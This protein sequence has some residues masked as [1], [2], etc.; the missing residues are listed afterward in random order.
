MTIDLRMRFG[1]H[2]GEKDYNRAIADLIRAERHD[3]A[4]ERLTADLASLN[5]N[6]KGSR[7]YRPQSMYSPVSV[8]TTR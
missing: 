3:L 4:G 6:R 1:T 7:L 2:E 8:S 5:A